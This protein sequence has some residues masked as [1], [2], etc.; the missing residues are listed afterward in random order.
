MSQSPFYVEIRSGL[1]NHLFQLAA[2]YAHAKR[3]GRSLVVSAR[4]A[5]G[6]RTY[7]HDYLTAFEPLIG[8]VPHPITLW[9]EPH[10]SY[11]PIPPE[12]NAMSGYFQSDKY[13]R[14][15]SGEICALFVLPEPIR[16]E[17]TAKHAA[18]LTPALL[19]D[20]V[21]V[22]VRR[23]DYV[24]ST[25]V[26]GILIGDYYDRAVA[27]ARKYSSGPLLIFS[28]DLAWC[29]AQPV[30]SGAI[31]VD[32]PTDY[33]AL[34]LMSQYRHIVIANSTFSWWAAYMGPQPK[35]VIAPSRW[36]GPSGPKDVQDLYLDHW[37]LVDA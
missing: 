31:F 2:G 13:F 29:R 12:P 37:H 26:H 24:A 25:T 6:K 7:Y 10:F 19:A 18:I 20:A 35:T 36:F 11:T 16:A 33:M 27:E 5:N 22:H 17:V 14:D 4:T 15:I 23:T 32:E 28:D 8:P 34:Y 1:C 30:F 9:K 21:V 3:H